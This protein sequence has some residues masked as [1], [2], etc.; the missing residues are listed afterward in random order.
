MRSKTRRI[1]DRQA[2]LNRHH[3]RPNKR[4]THKLDYLLSQEYLLQQDKLRR[5]ADAQED[6]R[7]DFGIA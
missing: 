7:K 4:T 6:A 1:A 3:G 2:R 5:L